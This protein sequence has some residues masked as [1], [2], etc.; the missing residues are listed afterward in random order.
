M[1]GETKGVS[2]EEKKKSG[3]REGRD[4]VWARTYYYCC[5]RHLRVAVGKQNA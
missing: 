3:E 4:C 5:L 1:N 2:E